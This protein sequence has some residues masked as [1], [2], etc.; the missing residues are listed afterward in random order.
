MSRKTYMKSPS[1]EVFET[2]NPE[3]HKDCENLGGGDKGYAARREYV[4]KILRAMLK[5]NQKVYTILR[6]VS[7]SGMSREISVCIVHK[8]AV[9]N[10]TG[11]V[12]DLIANSI[13]KTG[14]LKVSGCG[15]D[16]G[17]D[18]VYRM[19]YYLWPKGT[20]KP[21]GTRNG[22]PDNAGGYALKHEWL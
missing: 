16:M 22:I 14:G 19:G 10:I 18:V 1:G 4:A 12:S 5:P 2:S 13:G 20:R 7:A 21:H 11:L 8:G 15:M 3:Y 6:S 9:C 17:F